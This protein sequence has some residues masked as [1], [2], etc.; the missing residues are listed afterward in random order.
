MSRRALFG[1]F[2]IFIIK[3]KKT[4]SKNPYHATRIYV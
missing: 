4:V 1:G 3:R 2:Y